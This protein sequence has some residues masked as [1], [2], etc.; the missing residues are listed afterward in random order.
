L[1]PD[2]SL[3]A[4]LPPGGTLRHVQQLIN[5]SRDE[6][7]KLVG[8]HRSRKPLY[9][10]GQQIG[11]SHRLELIEARA[12][13]APTHRLHEQKIIVALGSD[14]DSGSPAVQAT[15]RTAVKSALKREAKAYL[16]RRL[17]YLAQQHGFT[18]EKV[19]F[20]NQSGRWGSCSSSGT[21]SLNIALMNLP[22]KLADY[23]I[24]HE[25]CH[26]VHLHHQADFWSLVELHEP[27]YK[28]LRKELKTH[29]PHL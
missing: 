11:Q 4:T 13:T 20:A 18:Y 3:Q 17:A 26:T 9:G 28:A 14:L 16:P 6:L 27:N 8:E 15:I 21:I 5:D 2:G 10:N 22:L 24:I 7:R 23:V 12:G 19:R 29:N 25:L 1:S